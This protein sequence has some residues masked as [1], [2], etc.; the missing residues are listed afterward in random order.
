MDYSTTGTGA[1]AIVHNVW[2][3]LGTRI[4]MNQVSVTPNC[5]PNQKPA[6][7]QGLTLPGPDPCYSSSGG[8]A[9]C[10][11]GGDGG[12]I[13]NGADGGDVVNDAWGAQIDWIM[14]GGH[15]DAVVTWYDT[16]GDTMNS[17]VQIRGGMTSSGLAGNPFSPALDIQQVSQGAGVPWT[18]TLPWVEYQGLAA[19]TLAGT[20]TFLSAWGGDSR[21]AG[22][23]GVW[24]SV[25]TAP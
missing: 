1:L 19:D 8:V 10:G 12:T 16:W 7:V 6:L 14:T 4:H 3:S 9:P 18:I 25:I 17:R 22:A 11:G 5:D 24:S 15:E 2:S 13:H 21:D 20:S 23:P